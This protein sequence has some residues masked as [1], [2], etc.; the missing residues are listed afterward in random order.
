MRNRISVTVGVSEVAF[1]YSYFPPCHS[2]N[3]SFSKI[4]F[5]FAS[6]SPE[7]YVLAS[8]RLP[9]PS[10]HPV[11]VRILAFEKIKIPSLVY[12]RIGGASELAFV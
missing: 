12:I 2:A 9:N 1:V 7:M 11:I 5:F 6:V 10:S 3:L 8:W 4:K